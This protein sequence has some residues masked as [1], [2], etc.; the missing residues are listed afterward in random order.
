ML[1]NRKIALIVLV[2]LLMTGCYDSHNVGNV[3]ECDIKSNTSLSRLRTLSMGEQAT[4]HNADIIISGIVTSDDSKGN[5]YKTLFIEDGTAAAEL[6]VGF[7]DL[8]T[9]YP[10]SSQIFIKLNGCATY[11]DDGTLQIGLPAESYSTGEIDYFQTRVVADKYIIRDTKLH[12]IQPLQLAVNQLGL[13]HCGRL[14]EIGSL[15]ATPSDAEESNSYFRYCD[16]S[17]NYVYIYISEYSSLASLDLP[18][19]ILSITGILSYKSVGYGEGK[20]FVITPRRA[21]DILAE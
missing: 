17:G 18:K 6:F 12:D 21:D 10:P 9:V 4:T 2:A 8:C 13:S 15:L 5:F 7:Y 19:Q 1:S 14:V 16:K 20:Q 11:I 3:T